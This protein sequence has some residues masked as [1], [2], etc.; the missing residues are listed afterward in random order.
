MAWSQRKPL[1]NDSAQKSCFLSCMAIFVQQSPLCYGLMSCFSSS[2]LFI[3][4][5]TYWTL[6]TGGRVHF[7]RL[8]RSNKIGQN[9]DLKLGKIPTSI[10]VSYLLEKAMAPHSSILAWRIPRTGE[11]GGLPPMGSPQ[12]GVE[13]R[14]LAVRTLRPSYWTAREFRDF[15]F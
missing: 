2:A 15:I 8:R 1:F 3:F 7:C 9:T 10:S 13:P 12:P 4:R 14:A 5:N 6:C 11:P